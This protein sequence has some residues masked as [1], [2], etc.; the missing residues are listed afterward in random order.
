MIQ[1]VKRR[2][3]TLVALLILS[4]GCTPKEKNICHVNPLN[5]SKSADI[6]FEN[7]N[8]ESLYNIYFF[9]R[10][11]ADFDLKT[12]PV[13]I[14]T[15][16]PDSSTSID[17]AFW[18]FD[19]EK[20]PTPTGTIQKIGYRSTCLL[21]TPGKYTFTIMPMEPVRGVE[22]VGLTVEETTIYGER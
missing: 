22:A 19:D 15:T 21:N 18:V 4:V 20:A 1:K 7:K 14:R 2:A 16:S 11:N 12:M 6:V 3:F 5:W 9:V 8:T 13:I 10:C 17:R